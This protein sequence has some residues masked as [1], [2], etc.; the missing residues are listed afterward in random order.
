MSSKTVPNF[1]VRTS[2][3]HVFYLKARSSLSSG[4]LLDTIKDEEKKVS[5]CEIER[6]FT[7]RTRQINRC[8][9]CSVESNREESSNYLFLPIPTDGHRH[10]TMDYNQSATPMTLM[11]S[12]LKFY[13]AA[14]GNSVSDDQT[15]SRSP[16]PSYNSA[17]NETRGLDLQVVF[18]SYFQNEQLKDDNQ[19]RCEHCR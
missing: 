3:V 7:I 19:Y 16:P 11:R 12:G 8:H 2:F 4:Y 10:E 6:L 15:Q 14:N 17:T 18:D 1:S 13:A 5:A 9:R